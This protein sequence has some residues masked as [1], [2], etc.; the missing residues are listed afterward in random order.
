MTEVNINPDDK[1]SPI[2]FFPCRA[3]AENAIN[4]AL[5]ISP[6]HPKWYKVRLRTVWYI[7]V[8]GK[9]YFREDGSVY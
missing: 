4:D 1:N 9:G 8:P 6:C 7:R 2:K 5:G 3:H